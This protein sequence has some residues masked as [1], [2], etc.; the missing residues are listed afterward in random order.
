MP[1]STMRAVVIREPGDPGVLELREVDRPEPGP[2]EIRVRVASS[3]VNRADLLQ[4]RGRYPAPKGWPSAI[5]GLEFAG[6]VDAIGVGVD[7]WQ[8]GERAMGIVGGGGYAEHVV[9][10]ASTAVPVPRGVTTVDAGAIP[11]VFM[12]AFDAVFLQAGLSVGETLLVHAAGSGVGSAAIQLASRAG[13]RTVGTSRTPTKLERAGPL[14]LDVPVEGGDRGWAREVLE[15]TGG[16]GADVILDLVGAPYVEGNLEALAPRGRWVVVGV[17]GGSVAEVDLRGLMRKRASVRG[18][19]LRARPVHEKAELARVF[20]RRVVPLFAGGGAKV[21]RAV[22]AP[23]GG[24]L[25]PLQPVVDHRYSPDEAAVAH[26]RMEENRTFGKL[27][28]VW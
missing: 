10:P 16:R 3:G 8:E 19:V 27:L 15:A 7:R 2:G 17:P 12:T 11:E 13:A 6:V 21:G 14:G 20:E 5:P 23:A 24:G 25:A 26:R 22:V 28:L 1:P 4:R 18:T 9:T